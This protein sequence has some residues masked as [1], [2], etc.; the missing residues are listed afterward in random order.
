MDNFTSQTFHAATETA[1]VRIGRLPLW[2]RLLA[3]VFFIA[4]VGLG[5]ILLATS[6]F[7][8]GVVVLVIAA[9]IAIRSLWRRITGQRDDPDRENVRVIVRR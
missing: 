3:W 2:Q 6:L 8:G 5:V 4:L 1:R 7:V 9:V